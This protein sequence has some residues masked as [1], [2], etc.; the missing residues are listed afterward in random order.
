MEDILIVIFQFLFEFAIDALAN[1]P[2]DWPSRHRKTPEREEVF[3]PRFLW[4]CAGCALAGLS[5]LVIKHTLIS[6][7]AFRVVNL[8]V[9]PITSAFIA[10]VLARRRSLHNPF[11]VPRNHFWQAFFFTL[12]LVFIRF[13]YA[14]HA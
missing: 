2:F 11:I 1:L 12:G 14:S 7:S 13:A 4:F 10:L 5:L 3:F 9:A 6:I 8:V